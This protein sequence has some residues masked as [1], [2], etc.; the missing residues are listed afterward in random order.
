MPQETNNSLGE[1]IR[2]LEVMS[3]AAA[4][5]SA[6]DRAEMKAQLEALRKDI[7]AVTKTMKAAAD[8]IQGGRKV[9]HALWIVGGLALTI[10]SWATGLFKSIAGLV[11]R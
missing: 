8:Q 2:A 6:E 1:R 4:K 11:I 7:E 10:L 3:E 5:R 9:L